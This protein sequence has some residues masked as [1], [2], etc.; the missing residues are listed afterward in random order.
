MLPACRLVRRGF[1]AKIVS[2]IIDMIK[3]VF[4]F[5]HALRIFF[6]CFIIVNFLFIA[7]LNPV[8]IGKFIG[9]KLGSAVGIST[10]VPENPYN[11]LAKDLRDKEDELDL[12]EQELFEKEKALGSGGQKD[13]LVIAM[14]AGIIV[15]FTLVLLNYYLDYK[16]RKNEENK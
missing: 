15:L 9:A 7:G 13:F 12:R 6:L 11:K 1:N 5:I 16:R 14:G 8:D 4:K 2:C 10:S 3:K